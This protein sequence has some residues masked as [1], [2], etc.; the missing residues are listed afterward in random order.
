MIKKAL[1]GIIA[2]IIT[3]LGLSAFAST[4]STATFPHWQKSPINVYIP[5]DEK[6]IQCAVHFQN[7]KAKAA[8]I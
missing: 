5:K 3:F 4:T 8:A 6:Q 1:F 7:G 2:I